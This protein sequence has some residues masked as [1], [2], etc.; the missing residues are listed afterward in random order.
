MFWLMAQ[1]HPMHFVLIAEVVGRTERGQ[2]QEALDNPCKQLPL[3][4]FGVGSYP[5]IAANRTSVGT[6]RGPFPLRLYI[7]HRPTGPL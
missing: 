4:Y 3:G 5:T 1:N 7:M 2:W 6:S